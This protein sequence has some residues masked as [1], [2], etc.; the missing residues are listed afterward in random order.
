MVLKERFTN[1]QAAQEAVNRL[2][3]ELVAGAKI[4]SNWDGDTVYFNRKFAAGNEGR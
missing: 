2:P 1:M 3:L 4:L